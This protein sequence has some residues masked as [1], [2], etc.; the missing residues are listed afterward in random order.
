MGVEFLK[1]RSVKKGK[2]TAEEVEKWMEPDF[3]LRIFI[4]LTKELT[5]VKIM[6]LGAPLRFA[7]LKGLPQYVG[8]EETFPFVYM[9]QV[10]AVVVPYIH[11]GT[12]CVLPVF[13]YLV[14]RGNP[15]HP[16]NTEKIRDCVRLMMQSPTGARELS[17]EEW[18][19]E[20]KGDHLPERGHF[21]QAYAWPLWSAEKGDSDTDDDIQGRE[22][23]FDN[24][25]KV[26]NSY[27]VS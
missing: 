13:P 27:L 26:K 9:A 25:Q 16:I 15:P 2:W 8:N 10:G 23:C 1:E 11:G 22:L 19:E 14:N 17:I 18:E 12:A 5:K 7:Q 20:T 4:R 3:C 24:K 21:I 6:I